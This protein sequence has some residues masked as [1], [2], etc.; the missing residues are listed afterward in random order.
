LMNYLLPYM[1]QTYLAMRYLLVIVKYLKSSL[2]D[3]LFLQN[4]AKRNNSYAS[5]FM[6]NKNKISK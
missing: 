2:F 5:Y 1:F 6:P 3:E 4:L